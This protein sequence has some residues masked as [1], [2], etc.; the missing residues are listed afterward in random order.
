MAGL[1]DSAAA[2]QVIADGVYLMTMW[3]IITELE[4]CWVWGRDEA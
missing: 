4:C 3:L 2:L 1:H